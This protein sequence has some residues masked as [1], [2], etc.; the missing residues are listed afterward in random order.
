MQKQHNEVR[1]NIEQLD[2]LKLKC[3]TEIGTDI[4]KKNYNKLLKNTLKTFKTLE[5]SYNMLIRQ[6]INFPP[7]FIE[8]GTEIK[9]FKDE[10][11]SFKE[12]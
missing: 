12:F 4:D 8:I 6:K 5:M 9:S 10:L 11:S 1:N 7:E 2:A 3:S